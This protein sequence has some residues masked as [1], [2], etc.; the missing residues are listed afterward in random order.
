MRGSAKPGGRLPDWAVAGLLLV[1]G[2]LLTLPYSGSEVH[3][4]PDGLFYEAQKQEIQGESAE[5]ARREVFSS[6]IA[7][8]LKREEQSLP[9]RLRR[10]DNAE[11]VEYS[12]QFYR[13]RWTVPA[14]AAALDPVFGSRALEEVSLIGLALLPALLYLLL[15]RRFPQGPSAAASVFCPVLP[16]LL[17][18]ANHPVT[19]SLGLALLVAGLLAAWLVWERGYAWL[20]LW[21]LL[22]LALSFTRDLTIVLLIAA[23]WLAIRERSRRMGVATASG[24]FAALPAP[25]IFAAPVRDN[26]AYVFN[27]FRIPSDTSWSSILSDYPSRLSDVVIE[28]IKYPPESQFPILLALAMGVIVIAGLVLLF[29]PWSHDDAFLSMIRAAAIGG[30]IT[31]LISVNYTGLRLELV[32]V[33]AIATGVALLIE[34]LIGSR[35]RPDPST[36]WSTS[37]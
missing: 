13:R 37:V 16:P 34:R 18:T 29:Y 35:A 4:S 11:W 25:L 2:V 14:L 19:D 36:E 30:V 5:E 21:I 22:V 7:A 31:I 27:E 15:R 24:V 12:S 33:P 8:S 6:E 17:E 9:P 26:L 3:W 20:P 32:F 28:D 10:V 23:G 1:F